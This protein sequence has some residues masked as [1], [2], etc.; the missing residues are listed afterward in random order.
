[1]PFSNFFSTQ[2]IVRINTQQNF[3]R[4]Y[5]IFSTLHHILSIQPFLNIFDAMLYFTLKPDNCYILF[6]V[7]G[8]LTVLSRL[9]SSVLLLYRSNLTVFNVKQFFH[10]LSQLTGEHLLQFSSICFFIST[11]KMTG[12]VLCK[13]Q[14]PPK[15]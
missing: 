4:S 10:H 6:N 2:Q 13:L 1:M 15:V 8:R 9:H 5:F 3:L 12:L 11:V 7:S 14:N